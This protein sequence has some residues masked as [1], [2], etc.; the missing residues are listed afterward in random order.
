MKEYMWYVNRILMSG[1]D[2]Y[3]T[4]KSEAYLKQVDF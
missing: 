2:P 4:Q 3:L 1:H